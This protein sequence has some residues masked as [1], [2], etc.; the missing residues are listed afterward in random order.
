[1]EKDEIDTSYYNGIAVPE[2]PIIIDNIPIYG[3]LYNQAE[4]E[5]LKMKNMGD[6]VEYVSYLV[7]TEQFIKN[8]GT[9]SD[10]G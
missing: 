9:V 2:R 4:E 8:G 7:A 1:M 5:L 6:I 10:D 3:V